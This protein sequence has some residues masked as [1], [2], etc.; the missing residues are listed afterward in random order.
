MG[1]DGPAYL[2]PNTA[3]FGGDIDTVLVR[4]RLHL[5]PLDTILERLARIE[6]Y[7]CRPSDLGIYADE[8]FQSGEGSKKSVVSCFPLGIANY[9]INFLMLRRRSS[10]KECTSLIGGGP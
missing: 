5:P 4:P 10:G 2:C 1:K 6:G 3:Y 7:E 9:W 8:S